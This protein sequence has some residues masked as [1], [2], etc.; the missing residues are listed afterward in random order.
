S[1]RRA[2]DDYLSLR[3]LFVSVAD[4]TWLR[5]FFDQ[6][7]KLFDIAKSRLRALCRHRF[8]DVKQG[9]IV[10]SRDVIFLAQQNDLSLAITHLV[11]AAFQLKRHPRRVMG[12]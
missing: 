9:G 5:Y 10:R 6:I 3:R 2:P 4:L 1:Q 12:A 7:G 8:D 11:L